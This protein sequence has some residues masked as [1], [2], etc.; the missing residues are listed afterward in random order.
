MA[1]KKAEYFKFNQDGN[2]WDLYYFKTSADLIVETN[3][4]KVLTSDERTKI[5][6]FLTTFNTANKLVQVGSGGK[7]PAGLIPD[8]SDTYLKKNNPTFD[9]ELRGNTGAFNYISAYNSTNN[10]LSVGSRLQE[11]D[12]TYITFKDNAEGEGEMELYAYAGIKLSSNNSVIDVSESW[13]RNVKAPMLGHEAV[14]KE[15]VD[16]KVSSGFTTR[17]PVKAASTGNVDI[18]LALNSLDGFTS[19]SGGQRV[20][21]KDQETE[22]ENGVYVLDASKKPVKV[23]GDSAVGSAVFV[24]NGDTNNDY[25]YHCSTENTWV[26]FS[27]PDTI[28]AG[29]GLSKSGTT[30]S[31]ANG[32]ITNA[33]IQSNTISL[34]KFNQWGLDDNFA[35]WNVTKNPQSNADPVDWLNS[36]LSAIKLL[37]GTD[38]YNT[39]NTQTIAGAYSNAAAAQTTASN[40]M[41]AIPKITSGTSNPSTTDA[42][43]GDLYFKELSTV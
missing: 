28:K 34:S 2:V 36:I 37:R 4:K 21:L 23:A 39:N 8:I 35:Y 29:A 38:N 12:S 9:G 41:A 27:K 31:I 33:M 6:N 22:S 15:Y 10:R 42:K 17:M 20:L 19:L 40:A 24:E 32:G 13:I 18:A 25:I 14:N 3:D 43:N 7:I 11:Q 16:N 1:T 5:S 26:A 30:L